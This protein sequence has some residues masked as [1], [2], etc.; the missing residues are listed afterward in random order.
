MLTDLYQLTMAYAA[1]KAGTVEGPKAKIG[2]F[3]LY[4]RGHPF[5]GGYAVNCGLNSA[6]ELIEMFRF[7]DDDCAYLASLKGSDG[8]P[9]F[10]IGFTEFLR[11][12]KLTIQVDA[13]EEGRVVF[14]NEP[15]LRIEGP[16]WQCQLLE[17]PLL[18]VINF[19]TLIA[20]KAARV[21]FAA[22]D[23]EVL[24]FGL[25]RAQGIDGGLSSSRAAYVGGADATS[26]VMAGKIFDI[27]LRGTHAH[28]WVMSYESELD[29]FMKFAEAMPNN[30]VFLVD[31]YD[32]LDGVDNAVKAG[33]WLRSKGHEMLG[34]RLDSGDFA[35]LSVEARKR[36]DAAGLLKAKIV[37][38]NDLDENLIM[39][40]KQQGARV[41]TWGVGTK[42]VTA[43][44]QPALGGVCKLTAV[45]DGEGPWVYR[46]KLSEQIAKVTTPG[47]HQIRRFTADGLFAGDMIYDIREEP[48]GDQTIVDPIDATRRKTFSNADQYEDLLIPVVR[49]G[50]VIIKKPSLD[51]IR[52]RR[53]KDLAL[54]HPATLRFLNPHRYPVGLESAL[55]QMK[56]EMILRLRSQT[57]KQSKGKS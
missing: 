29:S 34:I 11:K 8:K 27:P 53:R 39:S 3:D 33:L 24:E 5:A 56:S 50:Q 35:Y 57:G 18:N 44:D 10:E 52:A 22:G 54:L 14:A 9:L 23:D 32:S 4:F 36:L 38:S 12:M 26:N 21:K 19:E 7:E 45:R 6:L 51:E 17:T 16:V 41:D 15:L 48:M 46:I 13:V 42:L 49:D 40:L 31:T 30:S 47:I 25:R 2:V 28:S 20:T 55:H 37:A 43:Y 1:W